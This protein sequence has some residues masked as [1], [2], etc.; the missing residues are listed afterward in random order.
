MIGNKLAPTRALSGP[1]SGPVAYNDHFSFAHIVSSFTHL[2]LVLFLHQHNRINSWFTSGHTSGNKP[3]SDSDSWRD[4][5]VPVTMT[6]F[7][8]ASID[9]REDGGHRD[10]GRL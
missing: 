6:Y 9:F 1:V 5:S 3:D 2:F 7:L 4:S 10:S 8:F